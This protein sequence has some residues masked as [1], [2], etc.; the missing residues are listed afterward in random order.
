MKKISM[1]NSVESLDIS[2]AIGRVSPDLLKAL[3]KLPGLQYSSKIREATISDI[4]PA[5]KRIKFIKDNNHTSPVLK[6]L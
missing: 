1:P 2:S 3:A 5:N 4:K 6:L